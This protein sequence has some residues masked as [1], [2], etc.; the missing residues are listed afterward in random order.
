MDDLQGRVDK[1]LEGRAASM[2]GIGPEQQAMMAEW[3]R[4]VAKSKKELTQMHKMLA[5]LIGDDAHEAIH[6]RTD[7]PEFS[8]VSKCVF[9]MAQFLYMQRFD[10][11]KLNQILYATEG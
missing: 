11:L 6:D 4:T 7:G 1:I 10:D 3:D 2:I 9:L 8:K 5:E